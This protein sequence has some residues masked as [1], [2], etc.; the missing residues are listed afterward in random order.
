MGFLRLC[1][2]LTLI[3]F[4]TACK[5]TAV[6]RWT[7]GKPF[8]AGKLTVGV[9]Y[10]DDATN[11]YSLSHATGLAKAAQELGIDQER[12]INKFNV[13]DGDTAMI[14]FAI[15]SLIAQ[16]ANIIITT[17][18]G[19]MTVSGK[20]AQEYPNVIFAN[21]SGYK[22]N[23]RNFTNFF[24]RM[25]Q[26][27]FLSGIAAGLQTNTNK[28]GFV[29]AQGIAN[30]E[31]T[32]GLNAFAIGVA[33]VN[34]DAQIYVKVTH[35]WYHPAGER[36]AANLLLE[37]GCDVI[38]QHCDTNEPKRA[39][40][41]AGVWAIGANID[42]SRQAPDAVLTS[43]LWN[44]DVYYK[45]L[46]AS[47]IDGSFNTLPYFGGLDDGLVGIAPINT[48]VAK[49]GISEAV[50][51]AKERILRDDFRIFEGLMQTNTGD[52]VGAQGAALSDSQIRSWI[53]WYYHNISE[54]H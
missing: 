23:S 29:A 36:A 21:A 19:F 2:A 15:S 20:M 35:S 39:A 47:V 9:I 5:Q 51:E 11:G 26:A 40:Q 31:V 46:F 7:P 41:R 50:N 27:R 32:G 38:A 42:M 14:E 13:S 49:A 10:L 25:Y 17:S 44:W 3:F 6:E 1:I 28:I 8:C 52:F 45:K 34:P 22:Y 33:S 54:L 43:T 30:S 53:D 24:G 16:G 4:L 18:W 12:I 48:A 37:H